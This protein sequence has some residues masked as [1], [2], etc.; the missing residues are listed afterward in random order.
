MAILLKVKWV[1]KSGQPDP[2]QHISHIGGAS[3]QLHWKHSHAQAIQSIEQ[4]L[5]TYYV[6]KD[7]RA[8]KLEVGLAPNGFKYL[9]VPADGEPPRLLLNLP[10]QPQVTHA[11]KRA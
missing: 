4:D 7:A 9:K 5:F 2:Y 6:E 1:E 10:E 11:H 3:G 8:V